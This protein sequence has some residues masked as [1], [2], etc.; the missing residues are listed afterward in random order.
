MF[1]DPAYL[2]MMSANSKASSSNVFEL[3]ALLQGLTARFKDSAV[4]IVILANRRR[5][6]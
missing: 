2:A 3:G 5:G 1:I 4:P 6:C